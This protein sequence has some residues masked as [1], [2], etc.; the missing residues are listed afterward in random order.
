MRKKDAKLYHNVKDPESEMVDG[1]KSVDYALSSVD[2]RVAMEFFDLSKAGQSKKYIFKCHR[3]SEGERD[4]VYPVY[5][6]TFHPTRYNSKKHF[7]RA[8]IGK[9]DS[10]CNYASWNIRR[11]PSKPVAFDPLGDATS[12]V[13]H[14]KFSR[15]AKY[16]FT[17]DIMS[18]VVEKKEENIDD[19]LVKLLQRL[20]MTDKMDSTGNTSS[21]TRPPVQPIIPTAFY[22]SPSPSLFYHPQAQ[23]SSPG[24]TVGP[25][26][27]FG[28]QL[29]GPSPH[30]GLHLYHSGVM[31]PTAA[32][33]QPATL[34]NAFT[35]KTLHGLASG[36]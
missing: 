18:S 13:S 9:W 28:F 14:V 29:V 33:G 36:A 34:S 4:I 21:S 10:T 2:G 16:E 19:L 30:S 8:K 27:G 1:W 3:K 35:A 17:K 15:R 7:R 24:T 31:R 12:K 20:G 32:P 5:T 22:A 25:P 6:I 11:E 26:P 23:Y